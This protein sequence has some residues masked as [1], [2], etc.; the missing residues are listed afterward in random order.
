[1]IKLSDCNECQRVCEKNTYGK[2]NHFQCKGYLPYQAR[3]TS[4]L[5]NLAFEERKIQGLFDCLNLVGLT[6]V[7]TATHSGFRLEAQR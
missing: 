1:M 2:T 3:G 7:E 6:L 4:I 5:R